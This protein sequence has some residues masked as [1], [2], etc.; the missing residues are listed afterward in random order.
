L[1]LRFKGSDNGVALREED[2]IIGS[3]ATKLGE[4]M[5]GLELL[6]IFLS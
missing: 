2:W 4:V 5:G 1:R 6:A 3:E